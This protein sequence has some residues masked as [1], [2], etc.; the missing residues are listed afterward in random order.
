M[1]NELLCADDLILMSETTEEHRNNFKK[2]KDDFERNG[3]KVNIGK[4]KV[5]ISG[6]I[7]KEGSSKTKID[8]YGVS[9]LRVKANSVC[10]TW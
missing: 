6:S 7:M 3:L 5:K 10:A 2:W 4:T 9:S 1:L 8:Q